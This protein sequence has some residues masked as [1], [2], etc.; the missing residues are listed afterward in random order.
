GA[1]VTPVTSLALSAAGG[2]AG[3]RG[4]NAGDE[5]LK[6]AVG[7]SGSASLVP[8]LTASGWEV[9]PGVGKAEF[10]G[11]AGGSG[12][13]FGLVSGADAGGPGTTAGEGGTA[14]GDVLTGT[15]AGK[16]GSPGK[17]GMLSATS[18]F[19]APPSGGSVVL[20]I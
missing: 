16:G 14:D 20:T 3:N 19:S 12:V 6:G 2:S 9:L 10:A 5:F 7:A 13:V 15:G 11:N 8:F 4:G 18:F 1:E 17:P